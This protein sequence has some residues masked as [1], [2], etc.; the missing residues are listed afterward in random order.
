MFRMLFRAMLKE[1]S[2]QYGDTLGLSPIV[3]ASPKLKQKFY[4]LG[5]TYGEKNTP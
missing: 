4:Y 2:V 1:A 5:P 3:L